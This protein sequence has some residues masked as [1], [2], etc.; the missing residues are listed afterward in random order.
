MV[1]EYRK[2]GTD[3]LL[4]AINH[5]TY[6]EDLTGLTELKESANAFEVDWDIE[7]DNEDCVEI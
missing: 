1:S 5:P 2:R 4:E 3:F 6:L 7:D